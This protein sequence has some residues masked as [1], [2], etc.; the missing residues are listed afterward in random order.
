[1]EPRLCHVVFVS[2]WGLDRNIT[3]R[4]LT[5]ARNW[6][7]NLART[8]ARTRA[9]PPLTQLEATEEREADDHGQDEAHRL[10]HGITLK[11][12]DAAQH[13]V[14]NTAAIR[15]NRGIDAPADHLTAGSCLRRS[16]EA[17]SQLQEHCA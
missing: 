4:A 14:V 17:H 12:H 10:E 5:C 9:I 3:W 1:M 2:A 13:E 7:R 16:V 15:V 8:R 6:A 11:V